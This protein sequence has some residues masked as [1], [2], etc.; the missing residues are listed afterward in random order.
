MQIHPFLEN[1]PL[2][3]QFEEILQPEHFR[4]LPEDWLL[5]VTDVV[6]S[7]GAIEGGKYR[8]VNIIGASAIIGCFNAASK[9]KLPFSFGGDGSAICIPPNLQEDAL[10]VLAHVREIAAQSYNLNMRVA[11]VPV[12]KIREAGYDVQI[13]RYKLSDLESQP[14]FS[15]G[16]LSYAESLLK[17]NPMPEDIAISEDHLSKK[18]DFSGLEC[19]W[20]AVPSPRDE[21][22]SL[23]VS[24]RHSDVSQYSAILQKIR[25]IFGEEPLPHPLQVDK[26]GF[27]YNPRKLM[28]EVKIRTF[29][30]NYLQRLLY[31]LKVLAQN[32]I[33]DWFMNRNSKTSATN[34]ALYKPDMVRH[35]DYR[36]FDDSLRMV[37]SGTVEQR[38]Q[39]QEYLAK[40]YE[41]GS[42]Y[43]GIHLSQSALITCMVYRYHRQHIHFVDGNDGGY[44]EAARHLKKQV[45]DD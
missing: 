5:A 37:I 7:T 34:W 16:G 36:K 19:R 39:L 10:G 35:A 11:L 22:I 32:V 26:L 4:P 42:L 18:A 44:A 33:G 41:E 29:G 38:R 8:D 1:V 17:S 15:G 20:Q 31:L 24:T 40:L 2:I 14:M 6:D 45:G 43:Y 30:K 21:T 28:G 23:L 27:R 12:A 9:Q 13:T 25:E 3:N